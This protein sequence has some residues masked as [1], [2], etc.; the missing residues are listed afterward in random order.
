MTNKAQFQQEICEVEVTILDGQTTSSIASLEGTSL[1]SID[2]P[3]TFEGTTLTFL[4]SF[5]GV[6]FIQYKRLV[7][8]VAV[9]G[10]V[11][12]EGAYA[13]QVNDFAAYNFIKLVATTQTGNVTLK[14]KTRPL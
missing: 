4:V 10:I 9:A 8:G 3:S 14:L 1:I 2:I 12:G 6:N 7:D 13:T 11:S 5:D